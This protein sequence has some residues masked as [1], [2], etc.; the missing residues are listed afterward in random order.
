MS[1]DCV[2]ISALLIL[3]GSLILRQRDAKPIPDIIKVDATGAWVKAGD[4]QRTIPWH[5][6]AHIDGPLAGQSAVYLT[7]GEELW[8]A[9]TRLDRGDLPS[10]EAILERLTG[11]IATTPGPTAEA[12]AWGLMRCR[13]DRGAQV[14]ATAAWLSWLDV[15]SGQPGTAAA[16]ESTPSTSSRPRELE[17]DASGLVPA[18]P[19][20]WLNIPSVA[21]MASGGTE[22]WRI[23]P[24]R[25]A[26]NA[27]ILNALYLRAARGACGLS[28]GE[29]I[30]GINDFGVSLVESIVAA[31]YEPDDAARLKA[32]EVLRATIT[33][34]RE[35]WIEAWARIAIGRSMLRE[36]DP[37]IRRLG[38]VELLHVPARLE[39]A[40]PY[41]TGIALADAAS[42]LRSLNDLEEA[43][44][45]REELIRKYPGHPAMEWTAIREW[46]RTSASAKPAPQGGE[47]DQPGEHE[48]PDGPG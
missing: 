38:V 36:S 43:T 28:L 27:G 41:L 1:L 29:S 15:R 13:L 45:I 44:R 10:A 3:D 34:R 5:Q 35:P 12:I 48:A 23:P 30:A 22:Q 40:V 31:Q 4:S 46:P 33:L 47:T 19:P 8:R 32:R 7:Q 26:Q 21:V 9:L 37:E 18:L 39:T 20:I 2:L 17:P 16:L 42:A 6:I 11:P 14:A 25:A 24:E